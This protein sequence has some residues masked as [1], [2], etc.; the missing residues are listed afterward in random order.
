MD[1]ALLNSIVLLSKHFQSA[2]DFP[3]SAPSVSPLRLAQF[4]WI[5]AGHAPVVCLNAGLVMS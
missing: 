4:L 3:P 2:L 1:P 5:L